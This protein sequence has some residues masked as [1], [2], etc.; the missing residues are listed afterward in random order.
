M[1]SV[2]ALGSVVPFVLV[3]G[4][5]TPSVVTVLAMRFAGVRVMATRFVRVR[6]TVLRCAPV[7]ATAMPSARVLPRAA[8]NAA[9]LGTGMPL[10][11]AVWWALAA[12]VPVMEPP[13]LPPVPPFVPVPASAMPF[14]SD[15]LAPFLER[16]SAPCVPVL[17]LVTPTGTC[18]PQARWTGWDAARAVFGLGQRVLI[19][20]GRRCLPGRA[21]AGRTN[22]RLPAPCTRQVLF[23]LPFIG[24]AFCGPVSVGSRLVRL[25][26]L[27]PRPTASS[28]ILRI[29]AAL[30][31]SAVATSTWCG[32]VAAL[33]M[34][35]ARSVVLVMPF[36]LVRVLAMLFA[37][38]R[39][40]ATRSVLEAGTA[41]PRLAYALLVTPWFPRRPAAK[42][43]ARR[44]RPPSICGR[45]LALRPTTSRQ[46]SSI[47]SRNRDS[48][49]WCPPLCLRNTAVV[50]ISWSIARVIPT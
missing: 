12:A 24:F 38:G 9:A 34:L 30:R 23:V 8:P 18:F 25:F 47:S 32:V 31:S 19:A 14:A 17:V 6:A 43:C 27:R 48:G 15:R 41:T 21:V 40:T 1:R 33:A 13:T 20:A 45:A 44:I 36:V 35:F 2:P 49:F 4:T 11:K 7:L 26:F 46:A 22:R 29:P 50:I 3:P 37:A 39:V 5:A 42:F 16:I 28:W 10:P